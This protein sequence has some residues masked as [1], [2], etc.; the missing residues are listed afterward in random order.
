MQ[1]PWKSMAQED[2]K[3]LANEV[4]TLGIINALQQM[5]QAMAS[6]NP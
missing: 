2:Q 6:L 4:A 5:G 3:I 1:I